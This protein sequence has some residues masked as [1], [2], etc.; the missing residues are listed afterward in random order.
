MGYKTIINWILKLNDIPTLET[1]K[2]YKFLKEKNRVYPLHLPL[3]LVNENLEV[4][5]A[6]EI[7]TYSVFEDKTAGMYKVIK[8]YKDEQKQILTKTIQELYK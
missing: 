3:F 8:I 7:T 6:V 4:I 5:A 2:S 1:N